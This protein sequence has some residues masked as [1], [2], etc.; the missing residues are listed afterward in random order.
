M[1]SAFMAQR[2]QVDGR[3]V[4]TEATGSGNVNDTYL[5]IFRTIFSEERFILQRIN[6]NV[7]KSPDKVMDNMRLIT[8]HVHHRMEEE[9]D[10]ADRIWQLPRVIP[11]KDGKD[12]ALDGDGNYWRAITLIASAHSYECIQSPEHAREI[13]AVLGQFHRLISDFPC[14]RLHDTLEGFHITPSYLQKL[15]SALQGNIGKERLNGSQVVRDALKFIEER[16]DWCSILEDAKV[17]GELSLRPIHGDPKTANV[18]IDDMTGKGTCMIDLDTVKPGLVHYDIG[19]C[20][21]SCCNP[22]GEEAKDFSTIYFDTDLCAALL[23][24]YR[25]QAKDFLT[26]A[27][28]YYLYDAT[29]LIAF[30]LGLRFFADYLAGDVYFK[31][32]HDGQNLHRARVQ[33]HLVRSIETREK[34]IRDLFATL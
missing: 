8:Q 6:T 29:R 34:Q 27:D 14:D 20:L 1:K 2:F 7:F 32:N 18:M 5:V 23:K 10:N 28:R 24:G 21:R 16:R 3:L 30:E 12:Y 22:A 13:G 15:D 17:R 26:D 31:V 25:A 19:D 4:A 11:A 9:Q 33:F